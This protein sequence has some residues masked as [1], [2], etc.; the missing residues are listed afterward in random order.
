MRALARHK[1]KVH[2]I[3]CHS[4][5]SGFKTV[6]G[7]AHLCPDPDVAPKEWERFM[8]G[9][10]R[11]IGRRPVLIPSADQCV[12]A[13]VDHAAALEQPYV[14]RPA[15]VVT[16]ALPATKKRQY[17]LADERGL[18]VPWTK[19][20]QSFEEVRRLVAKRSAPGSA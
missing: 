15:S 11:E 14:F 4:D 3:D 5:Q 10:A 8:L 6:Y 19:F 2:C 18:P 12:T 20:V 7:K 17:E 9:L 1:L 16:Q 13:I